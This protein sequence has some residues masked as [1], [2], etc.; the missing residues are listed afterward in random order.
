[1]SGRGG[2]YRIG[3]KTVGHVD[4]STFNRDFVFG[5]EGEVLVFHGI[6]VFPGISGESFTRC[7]Q[8]TTGDPPRA[9]INGIEVSTV[10]V[11]EPTSLVLVGMGL[12]AF[13]GFRRRQ[14]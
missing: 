1:M 13:F 8:P 11:P 2:D 10:L 3:V 9:R 5:S 7:G 12:M 4:V 6:L 14:K